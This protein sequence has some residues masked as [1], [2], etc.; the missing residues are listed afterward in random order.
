MYI[1]VEFTNYSAEHALV[2][3]QGKQ[4]EPFAQGT[5]NT[6]RTLDTTEKTS[7]FYIIS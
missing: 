1:T 4:A 3:I 6:Y 5:Q 7:D 2:N